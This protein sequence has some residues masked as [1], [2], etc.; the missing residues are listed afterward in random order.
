MKLKG[1]IC[2]ICNLDN[3]LQ[4]EADFFGGKKSQYLLAEELKCTPGDVLNHMN[5]HTSE[6]KSLTVVK[7][8]LDKQFETRIA[9][10]QQEF[11]EKSVTDVAD[12]FDNLILSTK[13][14]ET[15]FWSLYDTK[16]VSDEQIK[17]VIVLLEA[18]RRTTET[19]LKFKGETADTKPVDKVIEQG[20]KILEELTKNDASD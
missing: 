1:K 7:Q 18:I 10:V 13:A 6:G 5:T 9:K 20:R 4:I 3:R 11:F 8:D 17:R 19:I 16:N 15:L 14:L 12:R 2:P